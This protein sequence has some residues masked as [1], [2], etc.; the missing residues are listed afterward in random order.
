LS[1]DA[2][3]ILFSDGR[4]I[5]EIGIDGKGLRQI[6]PD[7]PEVACYDPCRLPN[8]KIVFVSTACEQAV[9]C[10]GQAGVG[11]LHIMDADGSHER[12]LA[13]DQDLLDTVTPSDVLARE[14]VQEVVDL[15]PGTW[16]AGGYFDV[17]LGAANDWCMPHQVGVSER[18]ARRLREHH[19]GR[20]TPFLEPV[21]RE[22]ILRQETREAMLA[23]GSD[24]PF[25]MSTGTAVD[26]AKRRFLE[27]VGRFHRLDT[28]LETGEAD[29][30]FLELCE[31]R[32]GLFPGLDLA[33]FA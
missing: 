4:R 9:P 6:S 31:V 21:L 22:R 16:G 30:E 23:Q 33:D 20:G 28:M 14:P 12:R 1:W 11:N 18:L 29:L 2:K 17:W 25:L 13:Y 32:D 8:G 7:N 10:T 27:H 3:R 5:F 19:E 26:Y 15:E 24:W